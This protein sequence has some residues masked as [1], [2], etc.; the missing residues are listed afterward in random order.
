MTFVTRAQ[1]QTNNGNMGSDY[2]MNPIFAGDHPDP[3]ILRDGDTY[4][5]VHPSFEYYPGLPIWQSKDLINCTPVTNALHKYV[6]SVWAR[7]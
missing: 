6:G 7:H 4:Y 2:Y 3:S 1:Y 5:I